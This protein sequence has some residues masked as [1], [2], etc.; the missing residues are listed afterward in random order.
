MP[1]RARI[2]EALLCHLAPMLLVWVISGCGSQPAELPTYMRPDLLYLGHQPYGRLYVEVDAVEGVEV[3]DQWLEDLRAFLSTHCSK[4]DGIEIVRDKPVPLKNIKD[5]PIGPASILCL[6]GPDPNSGPQPAYLHVFF[7]DTD[8]VFKRMSK[9]PHIEKDCPC[10]IFFNIDYIPMWHNKWV[11]HVLSHEAGHI[12]GLCRNALHG[13]GA[14]CKNHGCLMNQQPDL[15]SQLGVLVGIPLK[16]KLCKNCQSDLEKYKTEDADPNL[17]FQGPFLVRR[18]EGYSVASLTHC[19]FLIPEPIE[20]KVDW[21]KDLLL[22]ITEYIKARNYNEKE[23][24][25]NVIP[26]IWGIYRPNGKDESHQI[27]TEDLDILKKA[28]KDPCPF[29]RS[30]SIAELEK[31]E[32][33]QSD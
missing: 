8:K 24:A 18:E 5:M 11:K 4:P 20:E 10:T 32:Q 12:L 1:S 3:P 19:H 31:L 16:I 6:D 13:D 15:L 21:K 25:R 17:A 30:N 26:H 27:A 7:Y 23:Y 14:H 2:L 22:S 28:T 33:E 29:I 9:S